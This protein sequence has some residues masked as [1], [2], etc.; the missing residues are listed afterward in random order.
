MADGGREHCVE[1]LDGFPATM[2]SH[3]NLLLQVHYAVTPYNGLVFFNLVTLLLQ[4]FD[5]VGWAAGRATGL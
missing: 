4:C 3:L 5:A 2:S 1:S